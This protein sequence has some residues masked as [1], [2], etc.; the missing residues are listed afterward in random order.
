MKYCADLAPHGPLFFTFSTSIVA[1]SIALGGTKLFKLLVGS[2]NPWSCTITG[3]WLKYFKID[4]D[5]FQHNS[6]NEFYHVGL[7]LTG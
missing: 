6:A 1:D 4:I 7:S 2:G 5:V 3:I